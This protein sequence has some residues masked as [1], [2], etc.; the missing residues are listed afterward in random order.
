MEVFVKYCENYL[1]I[2]NQVNYLLDRV[3]DNGKVIKEGMVVRVS[4]SMMVLQ[5]L[6][7]IEPKQ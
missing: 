1:D 6:T 7:Q 2:Q 5:I 4:C 3:L